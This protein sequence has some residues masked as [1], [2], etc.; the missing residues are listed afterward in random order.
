MSD[1]GSGRKPHCSEH[2]STALRRR[3]YG[4]V[5]LI[6]VVHLDLKQVVFPEPCSRCWPIQMRMMRLRPFPRCFAR[7]SRAL[8][9][10]LNCRRMQSSC[11]SLLFV[12]T[13]SAQSKARRPS[14]SALSCALL[15]LGLL[16]GELS[17]AAAVVNS[18]IDVGR[19]ML[20]YF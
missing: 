8:M 14:F 15:C 10:A 11:R 12:S 4:F 9:D 2:T 19:A 7:L 6:P 20:K 17:L 16:M 1:G 18:A 5:H 13:A 3:E